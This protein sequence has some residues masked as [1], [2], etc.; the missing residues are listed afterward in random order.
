MASLLDKKLKMNGDQSAGG[1]IAL[2][3]S[4]SLN[5]DVFAQV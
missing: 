5:A 2:V 3:L 1:E 4:L